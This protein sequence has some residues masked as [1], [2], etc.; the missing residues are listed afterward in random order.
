MFGLND[1]SRL[2]T[3]IRPG[4][5]TAVFLCIDSRCN[6]PEFAA[7][8]EDRVSHPPHTSTR[9]VRTESMGSE[10][11]QRPNNSGQYDGNPMGPDFFSVFLK[12]TRHRQR[13]PKTHVQ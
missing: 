2:T 8:D 12:E 6:I 13:L 10:L 11:I 3:A 5:F 1:C 9:N 7:S 4:H